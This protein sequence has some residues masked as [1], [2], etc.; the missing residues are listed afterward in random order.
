MSPLTEHPQRVARL[1]PLSDVHAAVQRLANRVSPTACDVTAAANTI[2]GSDLLAPTAAPATPVALRDGWAVASDSVSDASPYAPAPVVQPR[3]VEIGQPMP[4]GT[5][6][7]LPQDCVVGTDAHYEAIAPVALGDGVLAAIADASQSQ[8]L[9]RA[10][11]RLRVSDVAVAQ[12][13]GCRE[14]LVC[15]PRIVVIAANTAMPADRDT[16]A[17][18]LMAAIDA[19]GGPADRLGIDATDGAFS[20]AL[21]ECQADAIITIGGTGAGRS[22]RS[23]RA[24]AEVGHVALHGMAITPG[25][26]AALGSVA[27]RPVLMLPGRLDAAL[28]VWLLVG[29]VLLDRLTGRLPGIASRQAILTRKIASTL[30]MTEMVLIGLSPDG[31]QPLANR[32]F[33]LSTLARADGWTVVSP[34]SEGF[35]AGASIAVHSLP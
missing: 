15:V 32:S 26:T 9:R 31:A 34:E 3:W 20:R 33:P 22:D 11:E 4:Q 5:D 28:A 12:S 19:Q 23:V 1:A 8:V 27:N 18:F 2:L 25:E 29:R 10:G 6:A 17:P 7:I 35:P 21:E 14:A 13:L 16:V 24:L 30:G